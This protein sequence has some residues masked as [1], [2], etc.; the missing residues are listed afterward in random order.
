LERVKEALAKDAVAREQFAEVDE[1]RRQI[2]Q[3]SPREWE[4]SKLVALGMLS[5]E[6]ASRLGIKAGTVGA[7]RSNILAKL[8]LT[9]SAELSTL[10]GK[11]LNLVAQG[12][13]QLPE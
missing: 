11:A 1:V 7:H 5:K 3:L 2:S 6:I 10:V 8:N 4:I 9:T 13:L 12:R